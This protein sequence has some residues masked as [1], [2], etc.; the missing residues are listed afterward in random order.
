M[1]VGAGVTFTSHYE[2]QFFFLAARAFHV[3]VVS[4]IE[5]ERENSA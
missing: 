5:R 4:G 2:R 3:A 1:E